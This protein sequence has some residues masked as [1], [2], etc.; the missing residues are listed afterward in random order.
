MGKLKYGLVFLFFAGLVLLSL[1]RHSR[2]GIQNYHSEI[3]ADKAGYYVYLPAFFIYNFQAEKLPPGIDTA[4][5]GGFA[6]QNGKIRT[7]Y[8]YGVAFMQS[9]FFISCHLFS[10]NFGYP[11]DGFSLPYHKAI[12]VAAV[13]YSLLALLF[14]YLFLT[15]Y[16]GKKVSVLTVFCLYIGTNIF[17]YSI[18]ETGMSHV[19][20]FF[21]FSCFLYMA[22]F[23]TKPNQ[24]KLVFLAFG[25]VTGLIILVR[26]VN[27]L[28]LPVYFILN[29]PGFQVLKISK[30]GLSIMI[31]TAFILVIPQLVYWNYAYGSYLQ[32]S[33][34]SERFSNFLKPEVWSLWFSTNNGLFIYNPLVAFV[35]AGFLYLYKESQVKGILLFLYFIFISYVF[36]SWH[37][38]SYGCSYGSRPYVEY[39]SILALP[40][41]YFIKKLDSKIAMK[42]V[43]VS[44][45]ILFIMYNQ[46]LIFSYD[47]CWYGGN[48]DWP[49]WLRLVTSGTK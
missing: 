34:G 22:P 41:G 29:A 45:L 27:I 33:Y 46:K 18:F 24:N 48:W 37:D 19:Y 1:N 39:Y 49:E 31:I 40:F 38:W 8:T 6:I 13:T 25:L 7:K 32:Y 11:G 9:P 3:W 30:A 43:L 5:G 15:R 23:I 47:G 44:V 14:L 26:P 16:L 35:L 12:D 4:T 21:L 36:A 10:K 17:Y 20:S 42:P 28:F 2:S